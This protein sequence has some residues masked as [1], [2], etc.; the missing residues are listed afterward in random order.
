MPPRT[1]NCPRLSTRSVRVYA[2]AARDWTSDSIAISSPIDAET[3]RRSPS[4]LTIGCRTARMGATTTRTGPAA[5]S[6]GWARRRRTASRRPT[7]S[8]D[9][10]NRS[11]GRV[12]QAGNSA[13]RP[14]G[15]RLSRA[16][17][18]SSASRAVAVTTSWTRSLSL[19]NAAMSSGEIAVGALISRE[20]VA[21]APVALARSSTWAMCSSL[22]TASIRPCSVD[23]R[24]APLT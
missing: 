3:G 16:A 2:A 18:R 22:E 9:G 17:V 7:V 24:R 6:S 5:P 1:A 10:L 13:M 15:S 23:I 21:D 8:L 12:S 11:W 19:A 20:V 14:S 4:P